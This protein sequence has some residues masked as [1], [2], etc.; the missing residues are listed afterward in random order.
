MC[1]GHCGMMMEDLDLSGV[2]DPVKKH[3]AILAAN[4]TF[5][6]VDLKAGNGYVFFGQN[7]VTHAETTVKFYY[8]G[9]EA[10]LHAEP[11]QLSRIKSDHVLPI[12]D[13]GEIDDEWAYFLTP[14]C[15]HGD[16]DDLLDATTIGLRA[17]VTYASQL[18]L[19]LGDLHV[20]GFLHRDLKPANV[21][22]NDAHALVIGDFGSVKKL[23]DGHATIPASQ[24][25]LLYR[26]PE[27]FAGV[28]GVTG[29]IYQCGV[30]L[31]QLLGGQLSYDE[32][33]H[34]DARQREKL[35]AIGNHADKCI[36]VNTCLQQK[37]CSGA[38]INY[39]SLPPW[40]PDSLKKIIKKATNKDPAKRY[41]SGGAFWA[42]LH[43]VM[44]DLLDWQRVDGFV[45]LFGKKSYRL[46]Q[47]GEQWAVEKKIKSDWRK[48]NSFPVGSLDTLVGEIAACAA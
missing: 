17:A 10:H 14:T 8:W 1:C 46:V 32:N 37:I 39:S 28:Y 36:F 2:P 31:Y 24:H 18:L 47:D 42:K 7:R 26:P 33:A 29:D 23:P 44:P 11:A 5:K 21:Y 38:I 48:D 13:A 41:Q 35:K 40:V 27:S 43:Q 30:I 19:G 6:D 16:F 25:S 9:G 3:L 45:T 12:L 15:T 22:I 20:K 4:I 34:L